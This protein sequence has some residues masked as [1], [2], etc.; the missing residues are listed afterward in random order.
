MKKI[1]AIVLTCLLTMGCAHTLYQG[2]FTAQNN[3][4]EVRQYRL[5]WTQ[6]DR[7]IGD[8]SAGPMK[9]DVACGTVVEFTESDNGIVFIAPADQYTP[10]NT[11]TGNNLVCGRIDNL[12]RFTDYKEGEE[13]RIVPICVPISDDFAVVQR[14]FLSISQS[15]YDIPI[16]VEKRTGFTL[17]GSAHA[18]NKLE[19]RE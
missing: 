7:W 11:Q 1:F 13:I 3:L 17:V 15:P 12:D 9:L 10:Q 18:A 8:S 19:C 14:T 16:E 6:T 4:G 2:D 5:W